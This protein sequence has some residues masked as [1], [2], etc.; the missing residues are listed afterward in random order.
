MK[1]DLLKELK[2]VLET[3]FKIED[4]T[5][6]EL[7]RLKRENLALYA[8]IAGTPL[9]YI[10]ISSD[11]LEELVKEVNECILANWHPQGGISVIIETE[12]DEDRNYSHQPYYFQAMVKP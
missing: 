7:D 10:V 9:E 4:E 2:N 1:Q 5:L 3:Q 6:E 11:S 12:K 8:K